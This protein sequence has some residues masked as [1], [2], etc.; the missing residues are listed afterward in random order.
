M[1]DHRLLPADRRGLPSTFRTVDDPRAAQPKVFD[2]AL[3]Q[4]DNAYRAGEPRF[5]DPALSAA[6]YAARRTAMDAVLTAVAGSGWAGHLVLRGSV[7]LKTWFGDAA[8]E[9][10]DLDFVVT[11]ADWA[12]DDPRTEELF[13]GLTRAVAASSGP[14]RFLAEQ[15]VTEDIWTYERAPGRRLLFVWE[16]AG[17]PAGT[18]QLDFVFN[19]QLPVPAETLEVVPGAVL[20]VAGRE[21]SLAWKLLWL[22]TDMYPQGKDLYDAALLAGSTRLRYEVLRDVFTTGEAHYAEEPVGPDSVPTE[23]DWANFAAEYPQLAGEESEHARRLTA[24]LAPTFA[25]VPDADRAAWWLEGWLGPVR[26]LTAEE[27]FA[28]GQAWL[29]ARRAPFVLAHRLTARALGPAAPADLAA[30][31]LACPAWSWYA[32]RIADGSLP[33]ETVDS[34]LRA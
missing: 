13:H 22:T 16:A 25:E 19:E 21:L 28:A 33:P 12:L 23:S 26:R 11:P 30:A 32:G 8:R 6:W 2:P 15:T 29:A 34:W 20:N 10:G 24:A 27:G 4:F 5:T 14:V 1:S 7:V 3:K 31:M 17:L 18:L 9:P